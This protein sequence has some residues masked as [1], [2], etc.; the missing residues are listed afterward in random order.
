MVSEEFEVGELVWSSRYNSVVEIRDGQWDIRHQ[1]NIYAI[2]VLGYE[3]HSAY[4]PSWEL[5]KLEAVKR[6]N[7]TIDKFIKTE[8]SN[9]NYRIQ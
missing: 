7:L 1:A 3:N 2:W 4:Q 9:F 6:F 5:G 8:K